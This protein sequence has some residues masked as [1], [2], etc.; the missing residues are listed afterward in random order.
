MYYRYKQRKPKPKIKYLHSTVSLLI[1]L[2]VGVIFFCFFSE[3]QKEQILKQEDLIKIEANLSSFKYSRGGKHSPVMY[4]IQVDTG[5][6]YVLSNTH[7]DSFNMEL[8][9]NNAQIGKPITLYVDTDASYLAHWN[10]EI[11]EIWYQG[12]CYFSYE[13]YIANFVEYKEELPYLK[14]ILSGASLI[15]GVWAA[16]EFWKKE[17]DFQSY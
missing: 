4:I 17:T 7:L 16:F 6:K 8:F 1:G 3:E 10:G 13:Q 14:W 5:N 2:I 9:E 11:C 12:N 15:L